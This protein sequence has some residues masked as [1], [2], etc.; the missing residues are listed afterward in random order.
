VI[1]VGGVHRYRLEIVTPAGDLRVAVTTDAVLEHLLRRLQRRR[2]VYSCGVGAQDADRMPELIAGIAGDRPIDVL[3]HDYFPISPSYNLLDSDLVY[4]GPPKAAST[5]DRAHLFRRSDGTQVPL[6]AWQAAWGRVLGRAERVIV[7]SRSS[8]EIVGEVYPQISDR[9]LVQPHD[10][11]CP[12][13]AVSVKPD[14]PVTI[15]VLGNIGPQ[16]GARLLQVLS[17]H[18]RTMADIR[19]VLVGRIDPN[20]PLD[21]TAVVHGSYER[22][23][24]P[25][26]VARYGI[27][28][29]LVPSIWPET[30]SFSTH[31]CAATGLPMISFD[32]GAQGD[33]VG[34]LPGGVVLSPPVDEGDLSRA[35]EEITRHAIDLTRA[36]RQPSTA[37]PVRREV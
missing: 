28:C 1:R 18:L 23:D 10:L 24:I 30:F 8:R 9:I 21:R 25:H 19:L 13:P 22:R 35:V 34:K 16:K 15:G 5:A 27:T 4:R 3:L 17:T 31:E 26:L 20:Y 37:S 33:I 12:V 6:A 36:I 32:L 7:F 2:I 29:W 11:P 14:G